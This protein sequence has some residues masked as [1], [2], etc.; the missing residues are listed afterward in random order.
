MWQ[1]EVLQFWQPLS[2]KRGAQRL[3]D[4]IAESALVDARALRRQGAKV[5][6]GE[7]VGTRPMVTLCKADGDTLTHA[8]EKSVTGRIKPCGKA[9]NV[10]YSYESSHLNIHTQ[11]DDGVTQFTMTCPT[12]D[13]VLKQATY[14]FSLID[15]GAT[16]RSG[17]Q[18]FDLA[19]AQSFVIDAAGKAT[20]APAAK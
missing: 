15:N 18:Q 13:A 12:P 8:H 20:I 7:P 10:E 16:L 5:V 3:R 19:T 14:S 2:G 9:H 11:S 6:K 1:L 4:F 17:D